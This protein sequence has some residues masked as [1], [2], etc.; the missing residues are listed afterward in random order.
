MDPLFPKQGWR[1]RIQ[2]DRVVGHTAAPIRRDGPQLW[3]L[4]GGVNH[5]VRD[6]GFQ[7]L[8]LV[9]ERRPAF[10]WIIGSI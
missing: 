7:S 1:A 8:D 5:Q 4:E 6:A 3:R 2:Q 9:L 10:L